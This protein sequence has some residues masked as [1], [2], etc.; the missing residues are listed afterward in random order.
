MNITLLLNVTGLFLT[1]TSS[2]LMFLNS[3]RVDFNTY[4]YF[5]EEHSE[6]RRK[7]GKLNNRIKLGMLLI[8]LG[9]ALQLFG[10]IL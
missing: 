6:L 4:M 10:L 1:F 7:A 9:S 8:A 5:K 3:P 2:F